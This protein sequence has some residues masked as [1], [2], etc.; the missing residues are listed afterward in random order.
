MPPPS[1]AHDLRGLVCYTS[2]HYITIFWNPS[3]RSWEYCDDG[4]VKNVRCVH[5]APRTTT[6]CFETQEWVCAC[7]VARAAHF[8]VLR[9]VCCDF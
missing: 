4:I 5:C 6:C 2:S 3:S 7:Y 9:R 1:S 8:S